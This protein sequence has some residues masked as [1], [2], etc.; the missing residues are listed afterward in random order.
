MGHSHSSLRKW[1]PTHPGTTTN[2]ISKTGAGP[3]AAA[4]PPVRALVAALKGPFPDDPVPDFMT[5][6]ALVAA[7]YLD[8]KGY[9]PFRREDV[10]GA[11]ALAQ[12]DSEDNNKKT[13]AKGNNDKNDNNS[14]QQPQSLAVPPPIPKATD[15]LSPTSHDNEDV[16]CGRL[17]ALC[18]SGP[19]QD[20][21]DIA[22]DA[23]NVKNV[24]NIADL[25]ILATRARH[26]AVKSP[27]CRLPESILVHIMSRCLSWHDLYF[28]RC[29]SRLFMRLF[30]TDNYFDWL[31][32]ANDFNNN[33]SL[34]EVPTPWCPPRSPRDCQE[35]LIAGTCFAPNKTHNREREYW[36]QRFREVILAKQCRGCR[37][38]PQPYQLQDLYMHC[39]ACDVDH[40]T[41]LFSGPQTQMDAATAA[42]RVC[43]AHE[44][45]VRLCAHKT[46]DWATVVQSLPGGRVN[47]NFGNV[48][49]IPEKQGLQTSGAE[50]EKAAESKFSVDP[51]L[52][53]VCDH[54]SHDAHSNHE[55]GR[56][57]RGRFERERNERETMSDTQDDGLPPY[58]RFAAGS[59][60]NDKTN[61]KHGQAGRPSFVVHDLMVDGVNHKVITW[62]Y[63]AHMDLADIGGSDSGG[64][65]TAQ[66][67]RDRL[68]TLRKTNSAACYIAPLEYPGRLHELRCVDPERCGC[69][70]Y[71]GF[72]RRDNRS[73]QA[74]VCRKHEVFRTLNSRVS[75]I[76]HIRIH[77]LHTHD[78]A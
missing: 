45:H 78:P 72:Q 33:S 1:H 27:L 74:I 54:P 26:N 34:I 47:N 76:D 16:P 36:R 3:A 17:R 55:R 9:G 48:F 7:G 40:P 57:E 4:A 20:T 63:T 24:D 52:R 49:G 77:C 8:A 42:Q 50:G 29:T 18:P 15:Y 66:A 19:V 35:Q 5:A 70:L 38:V 65:I 61:D 37:A 64:A 41:D 68:R 62:S 39:T 30:A 44:G 10:A 11:V 22:P 51:Y 12:W 75:D 25:D 56:F 2:E 31:R 46:V 23:D 59:D 67:F 28:L 6:A 53:I 14:Q 60:N 43:I 71:P 13:E 21:P 69:L 58:T 32:D 73:R